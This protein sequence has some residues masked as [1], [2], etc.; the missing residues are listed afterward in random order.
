MH[1]QD[2][3]KRVHEPAEGLTSRPRLLSNCTYMMNATW[4]VRKTVR[5]RLQ[6]EW[7]ISSQLTYA[8]MN[9]ESLKFRRLYLYT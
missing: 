1:A 6:V 8:L 4:N 3:V 5:K 7:T 9:K 2:N